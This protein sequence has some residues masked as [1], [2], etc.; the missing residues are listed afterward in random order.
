MQ[1]QSPRWNGVLK[2]SFITVPSS[3][4]G[5][6]RW[7]GSPPRSISLRRRQT[8]RPRRGERA[9]PDLCGRPRAT[10]SK[11]SRSQNYVLNTKSYT[12]ELVEPSEHLLYFLL[13]FV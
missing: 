4:L 5:A 12:C 7:R 9:T 3:L 6:C 10:G 2:P 13:C 1:K 8:N 11:P